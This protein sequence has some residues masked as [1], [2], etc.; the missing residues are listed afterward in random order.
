MTVITGPKAIDNRE[1]AKR[2]KAWF[3]E[4]GF[5][6]KVF[7]NGEAFVLKARKASVFRAI[8]GADRAIEVELAHRNGETQVEIRQ[9]SW[10]TNVISN[11]AW[12]VATGGMNLVVSGW[13]VVVQKDLERYV[14]ITL[15]EF[16]GM[17]E[18]DLQRPLRSAFREAMGGEIDSSELSSAEDSRN[19]ES[20][21]GLTECLSC[22]MPISPHESHCRYCGDMKSHQSAYTTSN[23][24]RLLEC[25]GC[26]MPIQAHESHCQ[27]CGSPR[28]L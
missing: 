19:D 12:L 17:Q 27:Y 3:D 24:P 23:R 2:V 5:E 18:V 20:R 4:R 11:A 26:K 1:L 8:V 21:Y 15:S 10:K 14:R 28:S 25:V 7:Q 13:S 16:V 6:T 9:G 22:K